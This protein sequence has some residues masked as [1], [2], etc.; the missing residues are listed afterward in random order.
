MLVHMADIAFICQCCHRRA[1]NVHYRCR[2]SSSRKSEQ[3][4]VG[5]WSHGDGTLHE[6][7]ET[8]SLAVH[9]AGQF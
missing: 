3:T 8:R 4:V 2:T 7:E 6:A 1:D 9:A 5:V